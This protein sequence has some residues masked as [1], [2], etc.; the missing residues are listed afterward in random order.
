MS[1]PAEKPTVELA[2]S[3]F[4]AIQAVWKMGTFPKT[5]VDRVIR[6]LR[7]Q[8]EDLAAAWVEQH[9]QRYLDI[10]IGRVDVVLLRPQRESLNKEPTLP[11]SLK[12]DNMKEG[13]RAS[14]SRNKSLSN[15][16]YITRLK[17]DSVR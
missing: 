2:S 13:M 5:S 4:T 7:Y 3:I 6:A 15:L 8:E 1:S 17:R 11:G 12:S 16:S 9:R 14:L 10:A